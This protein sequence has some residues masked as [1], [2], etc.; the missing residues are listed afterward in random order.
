MEIVK[1]SHREF[2]IVNCLNEHSFLA[3]HKDKTYFVNCYTPKSEKFKEA[4]YAVK[5]IKLSGVSSPKLCFID[6]KQGYI[7]REFIDGE[8]VSDVI[9]KKDLDE[10]IYEQLF[11]NAYYAKINKMTL[12]YE[13]DKWMICNDKLVY[14]FPLY[15]IYKKEKDLVEKYL[16][17]WFVSNELKMFLSQKGIKIDNRRIKK[18]PEINKEIVLMTC[19]YYN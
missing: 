2:E 13:P 3:K 16:R 12:D 7:V 8:Y 4:M 15:I 6:K 17:L 11:K 5:K 1:I 19:K 14:V 9:A 10:S 18:E